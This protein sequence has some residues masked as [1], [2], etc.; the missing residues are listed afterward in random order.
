MSEER[1]EELVDLWMSERERGLTR[2]AGELCQDCPELIPEL[3]ERI[4]VVAH[5]EQIAEISNGEAGALSPRVGSTDENE[6][7]L[8]LGAS[9]SAGTRFRILRP[10]ARGG[11]GEVFVARDNELG[12]EVALKEIQLDKSHDANAR[13][14]FTREAEI[15]GGLEH[16]GIVPVYGLGAHPDGRPFYAMR[17][18][19]GRS[20][21]EA[22]RA[23]HER[24]GG[25]ATETNLELRRLLQRFIDVCEA[26]DYAHSRGVLHRDLKPG[27]IML[28]RYGETLVVDWGLAKPLGKAVGELSVKS[29]ALAHQSEGP[30]FAEPPL[31]P[32]SQ[33]ASDVTELGSALGTPAYMSPEQAQ[34]RLDLLCPASDV[35]SLGATLYH[36][37][38]GRAPYQASSGGEAHLLAQRGTFLR[39]RLL[40]PG[41]HVSLEAVC[42][43]AMSPLP[44]DRYPTAA[45][46]A[47][48]VEGFLGD[49]PVSARRESWRERILRFGRRHRAWVQAAAVTL[50]L[51]TGIAATAYFREASIAESNRQLALQQGQLADS[52]RK[53]ADDKA[54][55]AEQEQSAKQDALRRSEELRLYLSRQYLRNGDI[56][57]RE[58][59]YSLAWLWYVKALEL[60]AANADREQNHRL[61]IA[62][63]WR[64]MPRMIGLIQHDGVINSFQRNATSTRAV[65]ASADRTARVWQMESGEPVGRKLT[66]LDAVNRAVFSPDGSLVATASDDGTA[67]VWNAETG[68]PVTQP[69]KHGFCVL[70]VVFNAAGTHIATA[71]GRIHDYPAPEDKDL[72]VAAVWEI[73]SGKCTPLN[74][75]SR[76]RPQCIAFNAA[77]NLVATGGVASNSVAVWDAATGECKYGPFEHEGRTSGVRFESNDQQLLTHTAAQTLLYDFSGKT[78]PKAR[79]SQSTRLA[80]TE[81]IDEDRIRIGTDIWSINKNRK[82]DEAPAPLPD[83]YFAAGAG[84]T[85]IRIFDRA[86]IDPGKPPR[87]HGGQVD[88]AAYSP[89]GTFL[90]TANRDVYGVVARVFRATTGRQVTLPVMHGLNDQLHERMAVAFSTDGKLLATGGPDRVVRVHQVPGFKT[91]NTTPEQRGAIKRVHFVPNSET[92]IACEGIDDWNIEFS[93]W[94]NG[95]LLWP[96]FKNGFRGYAF[97]MSPDGSTFATGNGGATGGKAPGEFVVRLRNSQTGEP[98]LDEMKHTW[99]VSTPAYHPD[100]KLLASPAH[101]QTVRLW[102]L[103]TG[104]QV[105]VIRSDTRSENRYSTCCFSRDGKFLIVGGNQGLQIWQVEPLRPITSV[106]RLD[107]YPSG[108]IEL[109]PHGS[110]FIVGEESNPTAPQAFTL[111]EM[112]PLGPSLEGIGTS[113]RAIL[114][115]DGLEAAVIGS[116]GV[117]QFDFTPDSRSLPVLRG[118]AEL[119]AGRN[120]NER[121]EVIALTGKD[122]EERWHEIGSASPTDRLCSLDSIHSWKVR[123][124]TLLAFRGQVKEAQAQASEILS[125]YGDDPELKRIRGLLSIK[126]NDDGQAV[127]DLC[128]YLSSGGGLPGIWDLLSSALGRQKSWQRELDRVLPRLE[129]TPTEPYVRQV[130]AFL[131]SGLR[132]DNAAA[133]NF[134]RAIELGAR[135]PIFLQLANV[136]ARLGRWAEAKKNVIRWMEYDR[137]SLDGLAQLAYIHLATGA[138]AIKLFPQMEP[139]SRRTQN[140]EVLSRLAWL[141][142]G[143]FKRDLGFALNVAR[144]ASKAEPGNVRHKSVLALAQYRNGDFASARQTL[145][146]IMAIDPPA[147][148]WRAWPLLALVCNAQSSR[149]DAISNY[150]KA[151]EWHR[152][153]QEAATPDLDWQDRIEFSIIFAEASEALAVGDKAD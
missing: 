38:T 5:F 91:L 15:T 59:D 140:L 12:R 127:A 49:E 89:D 107:L 70:D 95:K 44:A 151:R 60:D 94:R 114:R 62:L 14:R 10:H 3:A 137:Q 123:R 104:Q 134:Q 144:E 120:I 130:A 87:I 18:I 24:T 142:V 17:F 143:S 150:A 22:I 81:V 36:L 131:Q 50:I 25:S 6:T 13:A 83:R 4:R 128:D 16:P 37:L 86:G 58:K 51:V 129:E 126:A 1:I 2:T 28:G 30:N 46:F 39:P 149:E 33:Q 78:Q 72:P 124:T 98:L 29:A 146:Q 19:R 34:G 80:D 31:T 11:L 138:E 41:I 20:L 100:G 90:A 85:A 121:D 115:G 23:F 147:D 65:T 82:V 105:G 153:Q 106:N 109:S 122:L 111:P 133:G 61:R 145:D 99:S 8:F 9:T 56:A 27:N 76:P 67:R 125:T 118:L 32:P 63:T 135:G 48:D 69:F 52:N 117:Q 45:A 79:I 71:C 74:T 119:H 75:I 54:Q 103:Q 77:G 66:H 64:Q 148:S 26:I 96:H 43:K 108:W 47:Q 53:L 110:W 132:Q 57:L 139:Q 42:L 7:T 136:E 35:F 73:A 92:L 21:Q 55:L 40:K 97:A 112:E 113:F 152:A 93:G 102:N 101:D 141:E 88:A 84:E 68:V 116:G